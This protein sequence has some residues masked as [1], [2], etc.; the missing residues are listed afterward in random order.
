MQ[1]NK[2]A[3]QNA[4]QW[5]ARRGIYRNPKR[6]AI[7]G[8]VAGFSSWTGWDLG[9]MRLLVIIWIFTA[10]APVLVIY[11]VLWMVMPVKADST[12]RRADTSTRSS[13][14]SSSRSADAEEAEIIG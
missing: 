12:T 9:V 1:K 7:A 14:K 10:F 3:A 2:N 5:F 4:G 11:L 8:V 6:A 13:S